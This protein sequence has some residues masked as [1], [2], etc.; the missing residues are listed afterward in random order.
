RRARPSE[1]AGVGDRALLRVEESGDKD[2]PIRHTGRVIKLIDRARQ[3]VLGIFRATPDGGGRLAP[4]D[5]KQLGQELSIPA[6]G[7]PHPRGGGLGG[8]RGAGRPNGHWGCPPRGEGKN[9]PA[10]TQARGP[11]FSPPPALMP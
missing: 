10:P 1:V 11:A 6:G 8:G 5:K 9:R 4:I 3:R 2:D 7:R